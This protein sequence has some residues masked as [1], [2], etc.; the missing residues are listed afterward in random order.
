MTMHQL[1]PF[2]LQKFTQMKEEVRVLLIEREA[3]MGRLKVARE[4]GDLSENGAYKYAKFELGNVGRK[5]R[6][7]NYLLENGEAVET[8]AKPTAQ[9]G[10]TITLN[11][12]NSDLTFLLVSEY[13]SD[14]VKGMLSLKSPIGQAVEGKKVGD[15]IEVVVPSG[16]KNYTIMKI[17]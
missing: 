8:G 12:G 5:L 13:E 16:V 10:T 2:T 11:D 7:L 9:F 6:E 15:H 4:M 1:I 17:A 3:L 14:P